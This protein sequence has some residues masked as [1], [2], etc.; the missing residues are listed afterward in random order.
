MW[1][2]DVNYTSAR[3]LLSFVYLC[4]I[5]IAL[6]SIGTLINSFFIYLILCTATFLMLRVIAQYSTFQDN[7]GFLQ[8]K[9]DYIHDPVWKAA[10]YV[11]VFSAILA[12]MAGFTQF[13]SDFLKN[14]KRLHRIIGRIYAWDI[15]AINFPAGMIMAVN[16]NGHLPSRIAFVIL[17]CLWFGF[18]FLAVLAARKGK[19]AEH[20]R[21]M[22]RSYALTFSAITL[23]SWKFILSRSTH[24]DPLH[25]YMID[26]WMGFVPNLLVAEWFIRTRLRRRP[27]PVTVQT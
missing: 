16:A 11:H 8:F 25:L 1:K 20:R 26:A 6:K 23:R 15:L 14:N 12:L 27:A 2:M 21:F 7:I 4:H 13:S 17:D 10:F 24:I 18:T 3:F 22:I 19:I 9:Q 5:Q